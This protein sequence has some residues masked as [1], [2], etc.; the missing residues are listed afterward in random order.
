MGRLAFCESS[1]RRAN[2]AGAAAGS[3]SI[4]FYMYANIASWTKWQVKEMLSHPKRHVRMSECLKSAVLHFC[5]VCFGRSTVLCGYG[6]IFGMMSDKKLKKKPS[7]SQVAKRK[8]AKQRE[9]MA[10]HM[11]KIST[12]FSRRKGNNSSEFTRFYKKPVY[13]KLYPPRPKN[14]KLRGL[15]PKI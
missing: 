15:F 13:H 8:D 5:S 6:L 4:Y 12:L 2:H 9:E 7:G 11:P 1:G 3:K 10:K 14:R